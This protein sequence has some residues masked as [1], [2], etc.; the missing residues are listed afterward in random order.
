MNS[1]KILMKRGG[2]AGVQKSLKGAWYT[3]ET[4]RVFSELSSHENGL[5][6]Q[7]AKRRL[8]SFGPNKIPESKNDSYAVIFFRQFQSPLIYILL[9]ACVVIYMTG[10]TTD[11]AIIL[12]V[13]LFNAIVGM[14]QEGKAQNTLQALKKFTKTSATVLRDGNQQVVSD[15]EVVVGDVIILNE[16]EKIPADARIFL[17]H[18]AKVDEASLTGESEPVFKFT[19]VIKQKNLLAAEQRNMVFKGTNVVAG[20]ARAVVVAT[21]LNTGMGKIAQ[22]VSGIDTEMPLK[23]NIRSLSFALIIVVILLSIALFVLGVAQ[24]NSLAEMFVTV[25]SLSVSVIPE[26]LPIVITL[27]LATGVWRMSKRNALVKKLQAVEALGQARIIAVDKTGTITKN[28]LVVQ[29]VFSDGKYFDVT[30]IG[31]ET[32]GNIYF[33]KSEVDPANHEELLIAGK[34][35]AFCG[36]EQPHYSEKEKVWQVIGDPTEAALTV[37]AKKVGY[38]K[39]ELEKEC[40]VLS[41]IPFDFVR[42]FRAT[43][44]KDKRQKI[45][46]VMGA[47][48]VILRLS[49]NLLESGKPMRLT[50]AKRNALEKEF[51]KLSAQGLRVLAFAKKTVKEDA[52]HPNKVAELT[53]GGFI[54]MKDALRPRVR[55]AVKRANKAGIK[56]VMITGDNKTTAAA[57]ATEA[58]IFKKGDRVLTGQEIEALTDS[59]LAKQIR[60]VSVFARVTPEHKLRIIRAFKSRNEIVAM[61]GDGVNDAPSLVAADL[62]VSMGKIGTEVAK[63]ASDIV[64]LDDHFDSIVSAVEE[65][66]N[67]YKTIKKVI[68]YLFSTSL[69]EVLAITAA[70]IL[71][72]PLPVLAAQII[73]LNFVTD[74]FLDVSLAMEP[75]EANLLNKKFTKPSKYLIDGVMVQRMLV[76]AIPMMIGSVY[77]FGQY[78]ET[79]IIKAHTMALTV[80][81]VFQWF[82]AWNCR[83][84]SRSLFTTNPFSNKYLLGATGIVVTLQLFAV[85]HPFFQR[86]LHTSPL[87]LREWLIILPIAATIIVVEELRKL[88]VRRFFSKRT[89]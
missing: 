11:A 13:L 71:G 42:K 22:E 52:L 21:G 86:F 51:V 79:D 8:V 31:Y 66:R 12:V 35:A 41:E 80:L 36:G 24:G 69:G 82:N 1:K 33:N 32:E 30:G 29:K 27:V 26:G 47:P 72:L 28:E 76:M 87:S 70:L 48:E 45:L 44:H 6:T 10:E 57:I 9:A 81:A 73:W 3:K 18:N 40:P 88:I 37:F 62:G 15:E 68:L 75:K 43:I 58:A 16:G 56:V 74:G 53:F 65:G 55:E 19:H 20:N 83:S 89:V 23:Q 67:I 25:V 63:A 7:E 39:A 5:T 2:R 50:D 85:Y 60:N 61:T 59:E 38:H 77:L 78:F 34:I 4:K 46:S 14:L 84:E 54:A 64:L 49:K 17:A